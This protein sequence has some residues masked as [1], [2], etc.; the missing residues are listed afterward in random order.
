MIN[1]KQAENKVISY[2]NLFC[3][4]DKMILIEGNT[5]ERDFGWIF[6]YDS[7]NHVETGDL[8]YAIAGNSPILVERKTGFIY[9]TGTAKPV[10]HYIHLYENGELSAVNLSQFDL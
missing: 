8:R 3:E 6:F 7:K 1:K 2:L 10:D 4:D 9:E 5:I